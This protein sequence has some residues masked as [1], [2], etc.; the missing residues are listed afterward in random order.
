M[1]QNGAIGTSDRGRPNAQNTHRCPSTLQ[2]SS[3]S[4]RLSYSERVLLRVEV[5]NPWGR[6]TSNRNPQQTP[7]AYIDLLRDPG[8]RYRKASDLVGRDLLIAFFDNLTVYVKPDSIRIDGERNLANDAVREALGQLDVVHAQDSANK[9][10]T[11]RTD[12]RSLKPKRPRASS[13]DRGL[14]NAAMAGVPGLEPRTKESESSVL[15]ITPYPNG[16]SRSRADC[17]LYRTFWLTSH[18]R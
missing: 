11:P 1:R 9:T 12:A 5:T 13:L 7:I 16:P 10:K 14:R 8:T 4:P 2:D 15:P 6:S 3:P 18:R 17:L